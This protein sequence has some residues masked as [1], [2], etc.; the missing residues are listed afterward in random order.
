VAWQRVTACKCIINPFQMSTPTNGCPADVSYGERSSGELLLSYGFSL[1]GP[2]QA[3]NPHE[4]ARM[5][6]GLR[7]G[8]PLQVTSVGWANQ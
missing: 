1:A 5:R 3:P 7:D 6:L 2:D 4:T 8:D